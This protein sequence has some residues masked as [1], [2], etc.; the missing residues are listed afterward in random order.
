M[1]WVYV[2]VYAPKNGATVSHGFICLFISKDRVSLCKCLDY[3]ETPSVDQA[4]CW[5]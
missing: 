1:M 2:C 4:S 5:P 3:P